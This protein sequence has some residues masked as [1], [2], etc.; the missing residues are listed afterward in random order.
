MAP[1]RE[2]RNVSKILVNKPF[3][4]QSLKDR[5]EVGHIRRVIIKYISA[6]FSN[7]ICKTLLASKSAFIV[8]LHIVA[9]LNCFTLLNYI[10][11]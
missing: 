5:K 10:Y 7:I 8:G 3:G 1:I 4:K 6:V 11:I 2:T 9:S